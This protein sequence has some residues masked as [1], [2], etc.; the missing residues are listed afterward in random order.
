MLLLIDVNN[1]LDNVIIKTL[2][3]VRAQF[4]PLS[5]F[6]KEISVCD[7][8]FHG[9]INFYFTRY[10]QV[11]HEQDFHHSSLHIFTE[12]AVGRKLSVK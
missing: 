9:K 6:R 3:I 1:V 10:S 11:V 4:F 8:Y 7:L 5:K 12:V 2:K